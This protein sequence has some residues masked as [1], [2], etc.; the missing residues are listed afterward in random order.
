[1]LPIQLLWTHDKKSAAAAAFRGRR[2]IEHPGG[3]NTE[4]RKLQS[5]MLIYHQIGWFQIAMDHARVIVC[6]VERVTKL[7]DPNGQFRRSNTF[8]PSAPQSR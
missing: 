8:S 7:T 5:A 2:L 4:V 3:A 1:M 6:V